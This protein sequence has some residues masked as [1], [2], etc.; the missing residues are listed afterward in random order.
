[1]RFRTR[2]YWERRARRADATN[3]FPAA[4][5]AGPG[6]V[7]H[8]C[9]PTGTPSTAL[10]GVLGSNPAAGQDGNRG[11]GAVSSLKPLRSLSGLEKQFLW[12]WQALGGPEL[13]REHRFHAVRLWRFDFAHVPTKVA[14]ELEGGTW[15]A[16][17]H[18]TGSGFRKD[19]EKYNAAILLGWRVFR[20]TTDMIEKTPLRMLAPIRH[21]MFKRHVV[22][23]GENDELLTWMAGQS[24]AG[25]PF[26]FVGFD[27]FFWNRFSPSPSTPN[28]RQVP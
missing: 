5:T 26:E 10:E 19:C 15:R 11:A 6:N 24:L 1:M 28:P 8:E 16:S 18:T 17:R 27:E 9:V 13:V 20:L 2:L 7:S 4:P 22:Y 21:L 23:H 25:A 3:P 12:A 14:I